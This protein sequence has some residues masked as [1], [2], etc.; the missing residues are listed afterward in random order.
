M[1]VGDFLSP[2]ASGCSLNIGIAGLGT[3]GAGTLRLLLD[4]AEL[5][6][7]RCGRPL[8]VLAVSARDRHRDRGVDFSG[9]AWVDDPVALATV[10]DIHVIVELIGGEQQPALGVVES[11]LKARRAVVTANKAL[12]AQHGVALARQAEAAGVPLRFEAAVAGGVPIIKALSEGLAANRIRQVHGILNGTCNYILSTMQATGRD[13][14]TILK[15]AQALGYAEA[16]PITDIEGIDSAHKL[17]ILTAVA[18]GAE[19]DLASVQIEGISHVSATDVAYA[20][21]LGYRIKL[22]GVTRLLETGAVEQR[23]CP[24]MVPVSSPLASV[25]GVYNAIVAEG[26][27]VG[28]VVLVGRGAGADPTASAVVA[29]LMDIACGRGG[30]P[31]FRVRVSD[32]QRRLPLASDSR[33]GRFYLRLLVVDRPGVIAEVTAIMRDHDVSLESFLQRAQAPGEAVVVV[34]TTHEAGEVAFDHALKAIQLLPSVL[35]APCA[36]R[37]EI[38]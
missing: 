25:D 20:A 37:I 16:D 12:I 31:V 13:F 18:F 26:D 8:R 29:D 38:A 19:V 2:P 30:G 22:L 23:V 7:S 36:I 5:I 27:F 15:E 10:P 32:L 14:A 9:I 24:C 17:A 4:N 6:A 21:E 35:E 11:A 34:M 1:T 28:K 3:V 33:R